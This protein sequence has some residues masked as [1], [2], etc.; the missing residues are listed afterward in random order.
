MNQQKSQLPMS[1]LSKRQTWG[2]WL[3]DVI[4]K[5]FMAPFMDGVQLSRLKPLWGCSLLFTSKS[6]NFWCSLYRPWKDERL[7]QSWSHP[8]VLNTGPLDWESCTLTTRPLLHKHLSHKIFLFLHYYHKG[9]H[10]M[11]NST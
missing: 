7:S 3:L 8:V 5:N 2:L 1:V 4:K 9:D 11:V 10:L 6:W